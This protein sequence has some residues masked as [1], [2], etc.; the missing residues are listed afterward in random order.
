M[1]P[2]LLKGIRY[3]LLPTVDYQAYKYGSGRSPSPRS[4]HESESP[5]CGRIT[6]AH[7][8]RSRAEPITDQPPS[9]PLLSDFPIRVTLVNS[10]LRIV[11]L[12][13]SPLLIPRS[14]LSHSMT[15]PEQ[16]PSTLPVVSD[17]KM[18]EGGKSPSPVVDD[19]IIVGRDEEDMVSPVASP[20]LPV[21]SNNNTAKE[22]ESPSPVVAGPIV[23]AREGEDVASYAQRLVAAFGPA[24]RGK[25]EPW[26]SASL[27]P[28]GLIYSCTLSM[29][30]T[31]TM[32]RVSGQPQFT[33]PEPQG[34]GSPNSMPPFFPSDA[35]ARISFL[36]ASQLAQ[37][38]SQSLG[39]E[40]THHQTTK[41]SSS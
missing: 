11:A 39:L 35:P 41:Q 22:R 16:T 33:P 20:T 3:S 1:P 8:L 32:W 6:S 40:P 9:Y 36:Y 21:V 13:P 12:C 24:E 29:L 7:L 2:C 17:D 5:N 19:S 4:Y 25:G 37:I 10:L 34:P 23:I 14:L 28:S 30:H 31:G 18:A 26:S 15:Y 27:L 38:Y